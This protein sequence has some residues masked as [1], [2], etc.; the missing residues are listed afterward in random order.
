MFKNVYDLRANMHYRISN[1]L[2]HK[3][4]NI[5]V[6]ISSESGGLDISSISYY[7]LAMFDETTLIISIISRIREKANTFI[8][9][10]LARHGIEGLIPVHGDILFMLFVHGELTMTNIAELVERKKSTVTTLVDKLIHLGYVEKRKDPSDSRFFL[11]SLT[12]GGRA[13]G[14][15]M[16]DISD[17]LISKVYKDMPVD[18]RI[19]LVRSLTKI[20]ANW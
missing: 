5:Q 19:R 12:S 15:C 17:R 1:T 11:I 4:Y 16:K 14:E 10:E 6:V 18:E 13:L 9:E 8:T 20:N 2:T 3:I 7:I